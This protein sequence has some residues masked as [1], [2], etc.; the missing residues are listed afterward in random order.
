[1]EQYITD[2]DNFKST[3]E[4]YGVAIIPNILTGEEC[5]I[6]NSKTWDYFEHISSVW[7]TPIKRDKSE[8]WK[9]I[10]S[11]YPMHSMLFQ[12]WKIGHAQYVWDIRQNLKVIEPFCKLWNKSPEELLVSFDGASFCV[13]P[14]I[15]N[16]G[17]YRGNTWLH[18]DQSFLRNDFESVQ[19]WVTTYDVNEDDAT[20]LFLEGS[21]KLHKKF[22]DFKKSELSSD[23]WYK[24]TP[25][26]LDFFIDEGC[27]QKKILCPK[28]SQVF[29][30]SRTVHS[31]TEPVKGRTNPN[32]RNVIYVCYTPRELCSTINLKKKIKAFEELRLTT[33]YPHR[34]KLFPKT[35][36][37]YGADLPIIK[38]IEVPI[39]NELG[40]KLIGY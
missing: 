30:D 22:K 6:I 2:I 19:S 23:D 8:T 9:K 12:H 29:W 33:H 24:F 20:L 27:K 5:D 1:M 18:T 17:W 15:T 35:P 40:R 38:E 3:L 36:R 10:Y 31:G 37:T 7:E 14:E 21:H 32:F 11:L 34:P 28:G 25:E 26:E 4:K 13:P 16:R 39:I